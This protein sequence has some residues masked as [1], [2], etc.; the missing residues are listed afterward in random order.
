MPQAQLHGVVWPA[1][2]LGLMVAGML[3]AVIWRGRVALLGLVAV[4]VAAVMVI[5]HESPDI[6]IA[7]A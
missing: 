3:F 7:R 4:A 2:A 5:K 6:L 1:S